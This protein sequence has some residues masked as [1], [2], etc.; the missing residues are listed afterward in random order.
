MPDISYLQ[1]IANRVIGTFAKAGFES[2]TPAERVF[3][4]LWCYGGGV[5]DGGHV[6]LFYNT[7]MD[8][9]EE[10]VVAVAEAGL[11]RHAELVERAASAIFGGNPVPRTMMERNEIIDQ[12]P[13]E[14]SEIDAALESCDR[15]FSKL[16]S[17]NAV[18]D[19][20]ESW[21]RARA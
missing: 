10:T 11:S 13:A 21:Y 7:Q 4:L 9:Y 20:L 8:Y 1:P 17:G 16:G 15:E 19:A 12:L 5:D 3:F 18:L 14:S 6:S 2:L